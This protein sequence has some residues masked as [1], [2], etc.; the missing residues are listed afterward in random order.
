[1]L[2][3]WMSPIPGLRL[4]VSPSGPVDPA[5]CAKQQQL[6]ERSLRDQGDTFLVWRPYSFKMTR[7]ITSV[8]IEDATVGISFTSSTMTTTAHSDS[9]KTI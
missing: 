6:Q 7:R 1:M 5:G 2:C 9:Q 4:R 8:G 3:S